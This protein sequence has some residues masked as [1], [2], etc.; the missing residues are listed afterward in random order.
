MNI[1]IQRQKLADMNKEM[2]QISNLARAYANA[3]D[4]QR[5]NVNINDMRAQMDRYENLKKERDIL[6][7][8]VVANEMAYERALQEQQAQAQKVNA[9]GTWR[10]VPTK[11]NNDVPTWTPTSDP[12]GTLTDEQYAEW[13]NELEKEA[14]LS[15]PHPIFNNWDGTYYYSDGTTRYE[16]WN[17]VWWQS[18]NIEVRTAPSGAPYFYDK[19]TGNQVAPIG[20][21][22]DGNPIVVD[23]QWWVA[24]MYPI[25]NA[26]QNTIIANKMASDAARAEDAAIKYANDVRDDTIVNLALAPTYLAWGVWV[27]GIRT[28]WAGTNALWRAYNTANNALKYNRAIN[29]ANAIWNIWRTN[30]VPASRAMNVV[31][32]W[33]IVN[34]TY[35][36]SLSNWAQ[37]YI[38]TA[39]KLANEQTVNNYA[40]QVARNYNPVL[41]EWNKIVQSSSSIL[42]QWNVVS[43]WVQYL[44]W[45]FNKYT[46][47]SL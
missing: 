9:R 31:S 7:Q 8:E 38:N 17:I 1:Q 23:S 3:T 33:N 42:P 28:A 19:T 20:T 32:E 27:N 26:I 4:G 37:R 18:T 40:R 12:T 6:Q 14:Y 44:N 35:W 46:P 24:T 41:S 15:N 21:D 22:K 43:N 2:Q 11:G 29:R 30:V 25:D 16:D 34:P 39:N 13:L 36:N 47:F 5:A 45:L 10:R